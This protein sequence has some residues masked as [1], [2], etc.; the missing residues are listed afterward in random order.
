M[1]QEKLNRKEIQR[2]K[3]KKILWIICIGFLVVS[4]T[5][6]VLDIAGITNEMSEIMGIIAIPTVII[7]IILISVITS[8]YTRAYYNWINLFILFAIIGFVLKVFH[9]PGA[10]VLIITGYGLLGL[11]S[12][13]IGSRILS[14]M[15]DNKFLRWFGLANS[16]VLFIVT[17]GIMFKFQHWPGGTAISSVGSMLFIISVFALTFTLPNANFV[18]WSGIERKVFYRGILIPM[19]F[20]FSFNVF[21]YVFNDTYYS[22]IYPKK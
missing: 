14:T 7:S 12:V 4:L 10:G 22:L 5:M 21:Y 2:K 20:V 17:Y 13:F 19:V 3:T 6:A 1:D 8:F 16:I 15:K 11:N 9:Y 18:K